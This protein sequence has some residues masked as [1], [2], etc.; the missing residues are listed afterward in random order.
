VLVNPGDRGFRGIEST[1]SGLG[2]T[3]PESSP[4]IPPAEAAPLPGSAPRISVVFWH[5][6]EYGWV[7]GNSGLKLERSLSGLYRS[8][9]RQQQGGQTP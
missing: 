7:D 6:S 5:V 9:R 2:Q 4:Q 3:K 1:A 8:Q